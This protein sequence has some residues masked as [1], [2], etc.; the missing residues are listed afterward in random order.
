MKLLISTILSV[1]LVAISFAAH[2]EK[3]KVGASIE[4]GTFL[5][6]EDVEVYWNKWIGFPTMTESAPGTDQARITIV[7]EGKSA[8]FIG[9]LS[10]NCEN[11]KFFWRSAGSFDEFLLNEKA[12]NDIVPKQVIDNALKQFCKPKAH[13]EVEG[14]KRAEIGGDKRAADYLKKAQK[15]FEETPKYFNARSDLFAGFVFNS[16][17]Q[18]LILKGDNIYFEIL[19]NQLFDDF[20]PFNWDSMFLKAFIRMREK[21][22]TWTW[23]DQVDQISIEQAAMGG[24][25]Y[26]RSANDLIANWGTGYALFLK[27]PLHL[28]SKNIDIM[29]KE[30]LSRFNDCREYINK[31]P[32]SKRPRE[33]F[34][35]GYATTGKVLKIN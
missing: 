17:P 24:H 28:S 16:D 31:Q 22:P 34:C 15:N 26:V 23:K 20:Q 19:Y 10:L 3:P 35:R 21:N 25:N 5:Y 14:D 7:G 18:D 8:D 30:I 6:W 2:A 13:I 33:S 27:S 11:N 12:A 1:C 4:G 32:P 9:N 29:K